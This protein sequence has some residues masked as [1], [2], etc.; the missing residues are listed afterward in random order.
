M[1][2]QSTRAMTI[3]KKG[4]TMIQTES[5][6][7]RFCALFLYR[8]STLVLCTEDASYCEENYM[9]MK[10]RQKKSVRHSDDTHTHTHTKHAQN[11]VTVSVS[12]CCTE[13]GRTLMIVP[14]LTAITARPRNH[15][16]GYMTVTVTV[17]VAEH[18]L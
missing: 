5:V 12:Q 9:N 10:N 1:F 16:H 3:N 8:S 11:T 17:T 4:D 18:M 14:G 13:R 7:H 6:L 15:G 2:V